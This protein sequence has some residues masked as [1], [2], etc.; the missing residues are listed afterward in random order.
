MSETGSPHPAFCDAVAYRAFAAEALSLA[1]PDAVLRAAT[2]AAQHAGK[3]EG[4]AEAWRRVD[5]G[6]ESL[7]NTV[8]GRARSADPQAV[9]AHLHDVLFELAGFHGATEDYYAPENSYLPDVMRRKVG[10]P[11]TLSMVYKGVADRLTDTVRGVWRIDGVNAPGHFL[12][13]V[14]CSD[15][16]GAD[17]AG[18]PQYIDPFYGGAL[19]ST[20]EALDRVSQATGRS[21]AGLDARAALRLASPREWLLRMLMNLEAIFAQR[22]RERDLMAVQELQS[23]LRPGT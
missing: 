6:L 9:L 4:P 5:A 7:A 19:L 8:R 2:A 22:S 16:G 17:H 23:L 11:L 15:L 10:I 21:S 1:R 20:S 3:G 12:V 18:S 14:E 13:R